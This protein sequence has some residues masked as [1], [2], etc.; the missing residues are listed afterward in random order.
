MKQNNFVGNQSVKKGMTAKGSR[1]EDHG[2]LK[3]ITSRGQVTGGGRKTSKSPGKSKS[4]KGNIHPY[5]T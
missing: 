5:S 4:G 1:N 3:E 2:N